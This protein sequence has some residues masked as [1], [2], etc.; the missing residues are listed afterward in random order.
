M[1]TTAGQPPESP[2]PA[3]PGPAETVP[4]L[5][6]GATAGPSSD[7]P[8]AETS[9]D[10]PNVPDGPHAPDVLTAEPSPDAQREAKPAVETRLVSALLRFAMIGASIGLAI[11]WILDEQRVLHVVA[12][13][14]TADERK[15]ALKLILSGGAVLTVVPLVYLVVYRFWK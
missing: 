3:A 8:R 13:Q 14:T 15:L 9:S 1:T 6:D 11:W 7:G 5:A 10:A 12:N 2:N 4:P